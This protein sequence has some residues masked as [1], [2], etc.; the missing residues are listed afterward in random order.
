MVLISGLVQEDR[1]VRRRQAYWHIGIYCAV[2]SLLVKML[3]PDRLGIC[4]MMTP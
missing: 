3:M 4:A 2:A 1:M